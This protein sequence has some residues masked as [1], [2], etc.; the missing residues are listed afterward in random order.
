MVA[1]RA[2]GLRPLSAPHSGSDTLTRPGWRMAAPLPAF[3][4]EIAVLAFVLVYAIR[5]CV[6]NFDNPTSTLRLPTSIYYFPI[7]WFAAVSLLRAL[8]RRQ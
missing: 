1:R 6:V 3:A 5:Q 7:V 4:L 2:D 8:F